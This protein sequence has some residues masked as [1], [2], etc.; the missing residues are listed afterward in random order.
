M[1][2]VIL[3]YF[4]AVLT[5]AGAL[6]VIGLR[7]PVY[8]TLSLLLSMLSL[9]ALFLMLQAPFVAFIHIAVYAGAI[10]VLFLFVIMLIGIKEKERS[11]VSFS[12]GLLSALA[13]LLLAVLAGRMIFKLLENKVP[14]AQTLM[15]SA[16]NLAELLFTKYL[17]PFEL[18]SVLI[19]VAVIGAVYLG[20]RQS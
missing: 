18:V 20:R 17:L 13:G 15:G 5:V 7:S 14:S 6:G 2:E 11:R 4:L 1:F 3:F 16:Q 8:S 9:A 12:F 19:L 10:I